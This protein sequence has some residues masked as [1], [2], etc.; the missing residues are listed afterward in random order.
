M[1]RNF[2]IGTVALLLVVLLLGYWWM[3]QPGVKPTPPQPAATPPPPAPVAPTSSANPTPAPTPNAAPSSSTPA[4]PPLDHQAEVEREKKVWD[5]WFATP[6]IFYG[7]VV[8]QNGTPVEG[9][10]ALISPSQSLP[11]GNNLETNDPK[12]HVMSDGQGLF[13]IKT[14]GLGV[15]IMVS[16]QG[17]YSSDA[18]NGNFAYVKG[19]G[20]LAVYN[21]PK[22][23]AI[24]TLRKK[25]QTESLIVTQGT[26]K[27]ASNGTAR[28]MSL[29]TGHTYVVPNGDI[30]VQAWVQDQ[31]VPVNSNKP[32]DWRCVITVPGGGIQVRTGDEFDF[33]APTDGY[34]PTD[35][36]TMPATVA[37]WSSS[38]SRSYFLRLGNGDFARVDFTIAA[39]NPHQ[40]QITSYLNPTPGHRNLEYDPNQTAS[41]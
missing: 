30:T 7:K 28:P 10:D 2:M 33:E 14:H 15:S 35:E 37:Q 16:K 21:D 8:D 25:G 9:A 23:P 22:A 40:F 32:Y 20:K 19:A 17:Y 6:I 3:S 26:V 5:L 39:E 36:I 18:S 13:S 38:A 27:I 1:N 34:Q 41:K 24:F 31:G 29:T 4:V 12:Y 11:G